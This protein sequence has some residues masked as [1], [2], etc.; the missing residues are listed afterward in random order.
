MGVVWRSAVSTALLVVLVAAVPAA[1]APTA[2][3]V[4]G[5]PASADGWGFAV[6]LTTDYGSQFCGGSL[7]APQWVLTAGHIGARQLQLAP[8]ST[9]RRSH[10]AH[11]Q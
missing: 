9:E 1:A 10:R 2:R 3:V 8:D 6:A 4:G 7:V 11:V 5:E